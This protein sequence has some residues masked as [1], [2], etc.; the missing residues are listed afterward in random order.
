[1]PTAMRTTSPRPMLHAALAPL[2]ATGKLSDLL[3][4]CGGREFRVH[5]AVVCAQSPF[6]DKAKAWDNVPEDDPDMLDRFFQFLYAGNYTDG[7]HFDGLP[8]QAALL[9]PAECAEALGHAP[10]GETDAVEAFEAYFPPDDQENDSDYMREDEEGEEEDEDEDEE[11]EEEAGAANDND[12]NDDGHD[13]LEYDSDRSAGASPDGPEEALH[14]VRTR[15]ASI[16][17]D[18]LVASV[19]ISLRVYVLADKYDV[20]ALK[21][22]AHERFTRTLEHAWDTYADFPDM[23]D[24]LF[25]TTKANDPLHSFI[26]GLIVFRYRTDADFRAQI[27]PILERH[28]GIAVLLL[29]KALIAENGL[30]NPPVQAA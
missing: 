2:Y 18:R 17:N 26:C 25:A 9:T 13:P 8:S 24:E 20:P 19:L 7:E 10:A 16:A 15:C 1:M 27:K 14:L 6:F 12:N 21:L 5:K 29:D 22:L 23:V 30:Q 4:T 11:E 28:P 3:V